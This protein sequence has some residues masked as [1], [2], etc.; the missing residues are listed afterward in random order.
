MIA[1]LPHMQNTLFG[2]FELSEDGT[3]LYSRLSSDGHSCGIKQSLI[4]RD[5]FDEIYHFQ[6]A[7][8]IRKH[9]S[10]FLKSNNS[11]ENFTLLCNFGEGLQPIKVMFVRISENTFN[12]QSKSIIVEIRK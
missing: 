8:D 6:N 1:A 11:S 3:I 2:L 7:E 4:G 9:F 5:F 12:K 10:A